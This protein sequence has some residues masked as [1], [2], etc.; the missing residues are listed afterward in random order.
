MKDIRTIY[1]YDSSFGLLL[2]TFGPDV[3][4]DLTPDEREYVQCIDEY[5][6]LTYYVI[7]DDTVLV[8]DSASGAVL[9]NPVALEEFKRDAFDYVRAEVYA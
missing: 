5:E 1:N 6:G 4:D 3:F 2:E 8:C 9:G 7:N